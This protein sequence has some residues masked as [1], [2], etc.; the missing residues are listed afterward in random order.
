MEWVEALQ[1]SVV[2][3]DTTPLIY[4]IE[5]NPRYID[6]VLPFFEALDRG[7]FTVVTSV[8]TLLEVLVHPLRLGDERLADQYRGILL[9][10]GGLRTVTLTA[11]LAEEASRIRADHGLRTPDAIQLATVCHEGAAFFLTNDTRLPSVPGL[12]ILVLDRLQDGV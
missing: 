9:G 7:E 2:G 5:E 6:L 11:E 8:I 10:A 3:L 1:G 4:F 12:T